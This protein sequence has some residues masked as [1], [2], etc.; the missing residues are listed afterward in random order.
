MMDEKPGSN[1]R[2][3]RLEDHRAGW[4]PKPLSP[5]LERVL[6]D[7]NM[8]SGQIINMPLPKVDS[9]NKL[10]PDYKRIVDYAIDKKVYFQLLAGQMPLSFDETK[11]LQNRLARPVNLHILRFGTEDD[12]MNLLCSGIEREWGYETTDKEAVSP[13]R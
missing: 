1:V 11:R 10:P 12:V 9:Y 4:K 7:M 2:V 6:A 13:S 8:E 3:I 5:W